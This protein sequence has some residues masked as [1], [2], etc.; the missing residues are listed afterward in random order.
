MYTSTTL[1]ALQ[2]ISQIYSLDWYSLFLL[3]HKMKQKKTFF[4]ISNS[5]S[6]IQSILLILL[7]YFC[8]FT[9][10]AF[11]FIRTQK[12]QNTPTIHNRQSYRG[13]KRIYI[14]IQQTTQTGT[15]YLVITSCR[16]FLH[17]STNNNRF[18]YKYIKL[19][20]IW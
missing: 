6:S 19:L 13:E 16:V 4:Y 9:F 18:V 10:L 7:H 3:F 2:S 15:Y 1:Y 17:C 20:S 12:S 11:L 5:D 14:P 8:S